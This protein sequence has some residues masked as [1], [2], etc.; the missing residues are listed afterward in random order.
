[1]AAV[2]GG[3][4]R[5]ANLSSSEPDDDGT[6]AQALGRPP[7]SRPAIATTRLHCAVSGV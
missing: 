3:G 1:M 4:G 2:A 6:V 5:S 7:D